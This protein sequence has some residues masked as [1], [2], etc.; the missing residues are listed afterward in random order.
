MIDLP[1]SVLEVSMVEDGRPTTEA[2]A[3]CAGIADELESLGYGR[4][5]FAEHHH[6]PAIGAFPPA[7]MTAHVAA[8]TSSI[9]VGSGGVLAPNHA[10]VMVAEQFT[11]LAGLHPDRIDLGIGRGPGTFHEGTARGL[12]RG[13]GPVTDDEYRGDVAAVLGLVAE[14]QFGALPEPWLLASSDAGA[15]LA[16]ALGLPIAFAHHIRP[17]NTVRALERY[18]AAFR[19]SRWAEEPRV[20]VCVQVVCGETEERVAAMARPM[21]VVK[22]GLLKGHS[23]EAFPSP[24]AA[25]ARQFTTEEEDLLAGF[26]AH[27][28]EGTPDHVGRRFAQLADATGADELMMVTPVYD[29]GNRI[30]SFE[31]VS[32]L[33]GDGTGT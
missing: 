22:L 8:V 4:I 23:E 17:D 14:L 18:R 32:E 16:A 10:P 24:E 29:L 3:N 33:K 13:A 9:R 20:L 25:A 30:R 5:W 21:D 2:L 19:P 26:R 31:L 1:L 15:E 12:R 6:S 28:A 11:T 7:V 27:Q